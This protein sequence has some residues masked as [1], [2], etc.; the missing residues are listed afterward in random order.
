MRA[1]A[2]AIRCVLR[3]LR[4]DSTDTGASGG[5]GN[6]TAATTP[7]RAKA[8]KYATPDTFSSMTGLSHG[9]VERLAMA[10]Y[11]RL[12]LQRASITFGGE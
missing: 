7:P 12:N 11:V 8:V 5:A 6:D 1:A 2:A 3:W 10:W 4:Y 9:T